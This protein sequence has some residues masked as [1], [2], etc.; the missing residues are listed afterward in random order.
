MNS[1]VT[2]LY[3]LSLVHTT[4]LDNNDVTLS[5]PQWAVYVVKGTRLPLGRSQIC[6]RL[7]CDLVT[8]YRLNH[9]RVAMR[10][11]SARTEHFSDGLLSRLGIYRISFPPAGR[12]DTWFLVR[13]N[14]FPF[15]SAAPYRMDGRDRIRNHPVPCMDSAVD[16]LWFMA[17]VSQLFLLGILCSGWESLQLAL[18]WPI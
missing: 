8:I 12:S 4:P 5:L 2:G 10:I 1:P 13:L 18:F 3:C 11:N 6:K 16:C 17:S 9:G 14:F 7:T 15:F